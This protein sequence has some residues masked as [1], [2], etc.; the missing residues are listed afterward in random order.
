MK[1]KKGSV[2]SAKNELLLFE[3]TLTRN[4][5]KV[6]SSPSLGLVGTTNSMPNLFNNKQHE[7]HKQHQRK[8]T[9]YSNNTSIS[10]I[11]NNSNKKLEQYKK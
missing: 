3:K 1:I 4:L 8:I 6:E 10:E 5:V 2:K 11:Y 7:Y 9:S